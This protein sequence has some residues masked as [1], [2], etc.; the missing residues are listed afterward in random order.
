MEDIKIRNNE[1]GI[2]IG[3]N[4]AKQPQTKP[5]IMRFFFF[6]LLKKKT[7]A[8]LNKLKKIDSVKIVF[9]NDV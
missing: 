5:N 4:D 2:P 3:F 6:S 7:I 1:I 8:I 9:E